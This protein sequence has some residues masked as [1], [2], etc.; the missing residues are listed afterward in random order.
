LSGFDA[1]LNIFALKILLVLSVIMT[2]GLVT[3][4]IKNKISGSLKWQT[5][6]TL[7]SGQKTVWEKIK[8]FAP[9]T[10]LRIL[11]PLYL[12]ILVIFFLLF[13][14]FYQYN[15]PIN[16]I[17][18]GQEN[19]TFWLG[20]LSL[21][22]F[23]IIFVVF[24][25]ENLIPRTQ[26]AKF[27]YILILESN[28]VLPIFFL[29]VSLLIH[30]CTVF[31][32]NMF[33]GISTQE[34]VFSVSSFFLSFVSSIYIMITTINFGLVSPV[35]EILGNI[36]KDR[37]SEL[38]K[39]EFNSRAQDIHLMEAHDFQNPDENYSNWIVRCSRDFP[40]EDLT[41]F[42]GK[43]LDKKEFISDVRL[44][45]L[46]KLLSFLVNNISE[47]NR[48]DTTLM[49]KIGQNIDD[50]TNVFKIEKSTLS[51]EYKE[52]VKNRLNNLLVQSSERS[53]QQISQDDVTE[54]I[55]FFSVNLKECIEN[56]DEWE[57]K[58]VLEIYENMQKFYYETSEKYLGGKSNSE[59]TY[60]DQHVKKV[61]E[62]YLFGYRTAFNNYNDQAILKILKST[63][64]QLEMS[65]EEVAPK[66]FDYFRQVYSHIF[67]HLLKTD[68]EKY[69]YNYDIVVP[70]KY[71]RIIKSI[72]SKLTELDEIT[73]NMTEILSN[74][75]KLYT[76]TLVFSLK[77]YK[78]DILR[79]LWEFNPRTELINTPRSS[80]TTLDLTQTVSREGA[81]P[82]ELGEYRTE[83]NQDF[84]CLQVC[85]LALLFRDIGSNDAESENFVMLINNLSTEDTWLRNI[86]PFL[87]RI[88]MV[89]ESS[90]RIREYLRKH[91]NE[92]ENLLGDTTSFTV[93]WPR[94]LLP[95]FACFI[96]LLCEDFHEYTNS[97]E[98]LGEHFDDSF[99][100]RR[101]QLHE[102]CEQLENNSA[103]E[104]IAEELGVDDFG[105]RLDSLRSLL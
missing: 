50:K 75:L 73:I 74:F 38:V 105:E 12:A 72:R 76:D 42:H 48:S 98:T 35:K 71:N 26:R 21:I 14:I 45:D 49:V 30:T 52:E 9:K 29:F 2:I 41:I 28:V 16:L 99:V 46:K 69:F 65:I 93:D 17:I 66:S 88:K 24:F 10:L 54:A 13:L 39:S 63:V 92:P 15:L 59:F 32:P 58:R 23:T 84:N 77:N 5:R 64:K 103:A 4:S 33:I 57:L 89:F 22:S 61:Q 78:Q 102:G 51:E 101:E 37:I 55:S 91:L 56:L 36:A 7:L 80:D 60:W 1:I 67:T 18:N 19:E 81:D 104:N 27:R 47:V 85:C 79:N 70:R 8:I 3:I 34:T 43:D 82:I 68:P 25:L 96:I 11:D 31:L 83:Y 53:Q 62:D 40:E 87:D 44:Q 94:R 95:E 20:H 100:V 90:M 86:V 97:A 6:K